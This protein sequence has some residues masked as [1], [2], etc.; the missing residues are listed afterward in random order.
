M[1]CRHLR[2]VLHT[3]AATQKVVRVELAE[4]MLLALA[5]HERSHPHFLFTGDE[6]W[7]FYAYDHR[8]MWVPSLDD[9]DQIE[10]HSH[11]K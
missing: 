1:K 10:R 7:M 4:R 9:V 11:F 3:L 6:S 5:K 8:T 2:W